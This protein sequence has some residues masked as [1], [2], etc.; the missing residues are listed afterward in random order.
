MIT[1]YMTDRVT[2][3]SQCAQDSPRFKTDSP[4]HWEPS[5]SGA[6]LWVH[7]GSKTAP[8]IRNHGEER[9]FTHIHTHT[10][11]QTHT[12]TPL[13]LCKRKNWE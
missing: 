11:S 5:Q 4:A 10:T 8:A 6:E 9:K 1:Y 2:I 12:H 13:A 3:L 7:R